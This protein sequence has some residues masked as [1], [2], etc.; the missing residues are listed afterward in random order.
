[1]LAQPSFQSAEP[2][3]ISFSMDYPLPPMPPAY[4]Q[5]VVTSQFA[6]RSARSP[7]PPPPPPPRWGGCAHNFPVAL[8]R[9]SIDSASGGSSHPQSFSNV[10]LGSFAE[11]LEQWRPPKN[12]ASFQART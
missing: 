4:E 3:P 12:I 7:S 10:Q 5:Q 11:G 8:S 1:M 2:M 9:A 6:S